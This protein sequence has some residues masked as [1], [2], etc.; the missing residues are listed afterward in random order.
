MQGEP[1]HCEGSLVVHFC[2]A[3][4]SRECALKKECDVKSVLVLMAAL[5]V[6]LSGVSF[7]EAKEKKTKKAAPAKKAQPAS[8]A[9]STAPA[10]PPVPKVWTDV[11]SDS[12]TLVKV[13]YKF[14]GHYIN[15]K[16]QNLSTERTVR[17]RYQAKWQKNVSG[18][19]VEDA[20]SEGLTIRLRKQEE[21]VKDVLTRSANITDVVIYIEASEVF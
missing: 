14:D 12:P 9:T 3:G 15:I 5:I 18:K 16:F 11:Q 17:I 21:L 6:L 7:A 2:F 8:A 13:A 4:A 19:W 1:F 20:S 10:V